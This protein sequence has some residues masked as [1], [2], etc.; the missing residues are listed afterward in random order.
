VLKGFLDGD[1]LH[2]FTTGNS[3]DVEN[4]AKVVQNVGG[5]FSKA[6]MLTAD[7]KSSE[8]TD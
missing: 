3:E 5:D 6:A 2:I 7:R 4:V 1:D 8:S